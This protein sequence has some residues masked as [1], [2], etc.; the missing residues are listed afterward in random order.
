M[1]FRFQG[2]FETRAAATRA[3]RSC[4]VRLALHIAS[5]CVGPRATLRLLV[6]RASSKRICLLRAEHLA[7][8]ERTRQ[9]ETVAVVPAQSRA[10]KCRPHRY[11]E[12]PEAGVSRP[13][14]PDTSGRDHFST[15]KLPM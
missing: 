1:L 4:A 7:I 8:Q 12:S 10:L 14:V 3:L 6:A 11:G 2:I 15:T 9:S 5:E 13:V